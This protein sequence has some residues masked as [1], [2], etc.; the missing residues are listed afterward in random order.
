MNKNAKGYC[1][2]CG[3][4]VK[5][6]PNGECLVCS[7]SCYIKKPGVAKPKPKPKPKK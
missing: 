4:M 7:S 1:M 2:R 5:T 6:T 3:H